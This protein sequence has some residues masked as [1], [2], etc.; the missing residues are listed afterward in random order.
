MHMLSQCVT[1]LPAF[2]ISD[3]SWGTISVA[4]AG[5][6]LQEAHYHQSGSPVQRALADLRTHVILCR[7]ANHPSINQQWLSGG[8]CNAAANL[9]HG[10][11]DCTTRKGTNDCRSNDAAH[12]G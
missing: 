8:A 6:S 10:Q 11:G 2:I 4:C 7:L 3:P 5:I 12:I 1:L 9:E